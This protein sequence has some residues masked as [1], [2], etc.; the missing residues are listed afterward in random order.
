MKKSSIAALIALGCLLT[1]GCGTCHGARW[2]YG[3]TS[4]Y[5]APDAFS[6]SQSLRAV[7]GVPVIL[8]GV[9][10]DAATFPLQAA[11]GV[12]PWWGNASTQMK[13]DR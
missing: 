10:F 5:E 11:F 2:A 13:P 4:I 3:A 7:L 8:G 12:W 6:E 9:A 1:S